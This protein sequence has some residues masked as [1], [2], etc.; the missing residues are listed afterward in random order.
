MH[1]NETLLRG[2]FARLGAR[3]AAGAGEHYHPE[4]F[5]T[6]PLFPRLHGARVEAFW[7]FAVVND[8][9]SITKMP[10]IILCLNEFMNY[11]V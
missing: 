2:F 6:N 11:M 8:V 9:I 5:F 1:P 4:V 10:G 7:A 3:D